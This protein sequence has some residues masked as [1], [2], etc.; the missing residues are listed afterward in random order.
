MH[1]MCV[2]VPVYKYIVRHG[3]IDTDM[4]IYVCV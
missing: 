1:M 3:F 2:H 4:C